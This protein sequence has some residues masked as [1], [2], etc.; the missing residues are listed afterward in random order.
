MAYK[1]TAV[2]QLPIPAPGGQFYFPAATFVSPVPGV[3][4]PFPYLTDRPPP[5][6][7][8]YTPPM[9]P[10]V[11]RSVER[12]IPDFV[13]DPL[14][15]PGE[16]DDMGYGLG[17][18]YVGLDLPGT[19][20]SSPLPAPAPLTSRVLARESTIVKTPS[21]APAM[22][23]LRSGTVRRTPAGYTA[24]PSVDNTQ[25]FMEDEYGP[26]GPGP[27]PPPLPELPVS[28]GKL[29]SW[30][31]PAGIGAVVLVGGYFL[32]RRRRAMQANRRRSGR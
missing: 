25:A 28:S 4:V 7:P 12:P 11:L 23:Q 16:E 1:R 14:S 24:P 22:T 29:P 5:W 13:E 17:F 9:P 31:L 3:Y 15:V 32:L 30:L 6:Q 2:G 27:L 8:R 18:G 20:V 26:P 10:S 19:S 21:L